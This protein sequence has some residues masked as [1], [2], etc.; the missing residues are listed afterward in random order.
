MSEEKQN[1]EIKTEPRD[2]N[3]L[4][5]IPY[6]EMSN[7]EIESLVEWKSDAKAYNTQFMLA[8]QEQKEASAALLELNRKLYEDSEAKQ[9]EFYQ[10]SLNRLNKAT[11]AVDAIIKEQNEQK[12]K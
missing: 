2:I 9:N 1:E 3:A 8:M 4:L 11:K 7:E 5:H 10:L 12:A 6:S